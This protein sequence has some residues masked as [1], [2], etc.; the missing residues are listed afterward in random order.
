MKN[1]IVLMLLAVSVSFSQSDNLSRF[2]SKLYQKDTLTTAIDTL[3][4]SFNS[5]LGI[6]SFHITVYN[7]S[8]ADT[9]SV[10]E[11]MDDAVTWSP[12]GVFNFSSGSYVA[13]VPTS[14]TVFSGRINVSLGSKLRFVSASNDGSTTVILVTGS[15]L[16]EPF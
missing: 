4:V 2:P 8:G 7:P 13:V 9:I 1:L 5:D 6:E 3:D 16:V 15:K 10:F 11:L 12:R 14:T